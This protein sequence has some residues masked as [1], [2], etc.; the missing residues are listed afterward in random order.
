VMGDFVVCSQCLIA[1]PID[2]A[3]QA[4]AHSPGCVAEHLGLHPWHELRDILNAIPPLPR[5]F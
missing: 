3:D 1:H 5:Q 2:M 4:F